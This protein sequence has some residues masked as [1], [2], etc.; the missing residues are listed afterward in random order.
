M[1]RA[2]LDTWAQ[3][4]QKLV[5]G[6]FDIG[7]KWDVQRLFEPLVS[8][9]RAAYVLILALEGTEAPEF[10]PIQLDPLTCTYNGSADYSDCV[11]N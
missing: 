2:A 4:T 3:A 5:V 9:N 1:Y 6:I 11:R 7:R 10:L 8:A